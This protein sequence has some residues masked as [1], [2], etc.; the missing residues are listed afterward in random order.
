MNEKVNEL[1]AMSFVGQMTKP[2]AVEIGQE[3]SAAIKFD[4]LI[5]NFSDGR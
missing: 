3:M 5:F 1:G 4:G 2:M